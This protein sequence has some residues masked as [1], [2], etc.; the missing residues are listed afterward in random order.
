M[1]I[2]GRTALDRGRYWAKFSASPAEPRAG[3]VAEQRAIIFAWE[4]WLDRAI[5]AL[6]QTCV[7]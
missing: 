1:A 6:A 3:W 7:E 5:K 4:S 2:V